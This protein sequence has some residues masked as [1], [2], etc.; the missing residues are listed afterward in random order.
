[1]KPTA[2]NKMLTAAL[3]ACLILGAAI[4]VHA[5]YIDID[6]F[7]SNQ[8]VTLGAGGPGMAFGST[9]AQG[10]ALGD[11]RDILV[12]RTNTDGANIAQVGA[13]L[14]TNVLVFNEN[15]FA[16]GSVAVVYDGIDGSSE[17]NFSGLGS[18]DLTEGGL[19]D[20]FWIRGGADIAGGFFTLSVFSS[21]N[22]YSTLTWAVPG[23]LG[24]DFF[25]PFSGMTNFGSGAD[26]MDVNAIVFEMNGLGQAG[27]DIG[28]SI[29]A[30]IP[31]PLVL[32][33][34]SALAAI[35]LLRRRLT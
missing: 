23:S 7:Y 25:I 16:Y 34:L 31:E 9:N 27:L 24:N 15:N 20:Q 22:D 32:W 30:V 12:T 17:T 2:H 4:H 14:G 18:F 10:V 21:S 35:A 28:I 5:G 3:G 19:N 8:T 13:L 29:F 6:T 33:P 26:F 11:E 1:M